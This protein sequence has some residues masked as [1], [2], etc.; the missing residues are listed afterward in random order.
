MV[1]QV[2]STVT[3]LGAE[4]LD[5]EGILRVIGGGGFLPTEDS[6]APYYFSLARLKISVPHGARIYAQLL[7]SLR[8]RI[9]TD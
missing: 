6:L 1:F 8:H 2:K 3:N 9:H 5:T 7:D 4:C